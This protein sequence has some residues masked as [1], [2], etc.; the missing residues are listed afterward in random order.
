MPQTEKIFSKDLTTG[1]HNI[2][3]LLKLTNKKKMIQFLKW[4]I[5]LDRHITKDDIQPANNFEDNEN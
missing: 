4:T 1:I 3:K 2:Q 5:H